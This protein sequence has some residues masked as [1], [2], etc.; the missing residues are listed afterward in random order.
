MIAVCVIA[1]CVIA[2]C[3]IAVCVIAVCVIAVCVI[4]KKV[5]SSRTL[6]FGVWISP[7]PSVLCDSVE[8]ETTDL[9]R[10]RS[11]SDGNHET[12]EISNFKLAVHLLS[13]SF[14]RLMADNGGRMDRFTSPRNLYPS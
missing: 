1:V 3:V 7:Y 8:N 12:A 5:P 14:E 4:A 9:E 13:G 11:N 2:V 10:M 6:R